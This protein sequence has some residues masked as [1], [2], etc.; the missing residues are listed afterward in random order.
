MEPFLILLLKTEG[1]GGGRETGRT[2]EKSEHEM[3]LRER[4]ERLIHTQRGCE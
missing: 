4:V 2:H 3:E 1:E